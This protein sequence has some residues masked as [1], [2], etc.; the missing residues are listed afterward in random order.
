MIP[1]KKRNA[2]IPEPII[3]V[4]KTTPP[5]AMDIKYYAEYP[6]EFDD[7]AVNLEFINFSFTFFE[8]DASQRSPAYSF[9]IDIKDLETGEVKSFMQLRNKPK[10]RYWQ[11]SAEIK[12]QK[13]NE[14]ITGEEDS[15]EIRGAVVNA[16]I[17]VTP[18]ND[19]GRGKTSTFI[20][21]F[22]NLSFTRSTN[23]MENLP[24]SILTKY[25][26]LYSDTPYDRK[27]RP[28]IMYIYIGTSFADVELDKIL[29]NESEYYFDSLTNY[30][31][32]NSL[33]YRWVIH[34]D[35]YYKLD[36]TGWHSALTEEQEFIET[37]VE[38]MLPD[39]R[40]FLTASGTDFGEPHVY[41]VAVENPMDPQDTIIIYLMKDTRWQL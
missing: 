34:D 37:L 11:R 13:E 21:P 19:F 28:K 36:N 30:Q 40:D 29:L 7:D 14:E 39:Y 22:K 6:D 9:L 8:S 18:V 33:T 27:N 1:D 20:L 41:K 16:R 25:W 3:R 35:G 32:I 15:R 24:N 5:K 17:Y 26:P 31:T 12:K 4:D 23:N 2:F 10:Y 38:S